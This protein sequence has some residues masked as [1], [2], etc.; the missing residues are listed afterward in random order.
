M[1]TRIAGWILA[2]DIAW[3][4]MI[5]GHGMRYARLGPYPPPSYPVLVLTVAVMWMLLFRTFSLDCLQGGWRFHNV[6]SRILRAT[7]IWMILA[8]ALAYLTRVYYSAFALIVLGAMLFVG[9]LLIRVGMYCLMRRQHSRGH[10]RR[11]VLVGK[12]RFTREFAFTICP[13]P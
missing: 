12:E 3:Q 13:A 4:V 6:L 9:F 2:L 1:N 7:A 8:T 10:T 11:V 5:L